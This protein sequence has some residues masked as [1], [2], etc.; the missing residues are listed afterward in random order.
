MVQPDTVSDMVEGR[1]V[2]KPP[3]IS[4]CVHIPT[5]QFKENLST[6]VKR[7]G[8]MIKISLIDLGVI[9]INILEPVLSNFTT[10]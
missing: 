3:F 5:S 1:N 8:S 4:D 9:S 10:R 7:E 6:K 2:T